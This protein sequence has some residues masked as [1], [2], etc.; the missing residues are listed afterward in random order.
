VS[1]QDLYGAEDRRKHL[2]MVQTVVSRMAAASSTS[3]GWLLPV[4]TATYGF[5]LVQCEPMVAGLGIV[6]IAVFGVLDAHYLR[7]ERAFRVLFRE[8]ARNKVR[9]YDMNV[10]RYFHKPNGDEDD[11][12]DENCHWWHVICSWALLGFYGPLVVVGAAVIVIASL[13]R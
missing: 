10:K 5:A 1:D 6:A 11:E 13:Y 12:R 7:Q 2:D 4:V 3:K 8:V 9:D